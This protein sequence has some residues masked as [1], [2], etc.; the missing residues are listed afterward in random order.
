[1]WSQIASG[2]FINLGEIVNHEDKLPE[3]TRGKLV[4]ALRTP[5]GQ[6]LCNDLQYQLSNR[7]IPETQVT[8]SGSNMNIVWRKD[9]P[10][11][12]AILAII[13]GVIILA[14]LIVSWQ[15]FKEI[16]LTVGKPVTTI[17]V[18]A[19]LILLGLFV[20]WLFRQGKFAPTGGTT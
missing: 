11:L 8:A 5:I 20:F 6:D 18:L 19:G 10:F 16:N 13:L 3:G 17:L 1:M 15:F 14:I 7:G 4:L 2:G 12:A 9:S